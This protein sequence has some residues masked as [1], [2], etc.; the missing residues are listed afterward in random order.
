MRPLLILFAV[1]IIP[2]G[3]LTGNQA[4]RSHLVGPGT[5]TIISGRCVKLKGW[6]AEV[7]K[8]MPAEGQTP[9]FLSL[10][11]NLGDRKHN[12]ES[13]LRILPPDVE[14]LQASSIYQTEP[15]GFSDQP[16]FLNQVVM[17]ET[18][19]DPHGLLVYLK[20]I[21]NTIGRKPTFRFG[22]RLADIDIIFYGDQIVDTEEL[23]IPHPRFQERA[24]VLVPLAEIAPDLQIPGSDHTVAELLV[25]L[26]KEGVV[27]FQ[28]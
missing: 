3:W 1:E 27:P 12:L 22:P 11:S 14:V 2:K 26:D 15:W 21:E 20:G 8:S 6:L 5:P 7:S 17:A 9:I 16:E 13:I 19:L 4:I 25:G 23:Q 10:G 28:E 24:F 18:R